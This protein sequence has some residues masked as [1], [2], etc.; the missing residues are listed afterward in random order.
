MGAYIYFAVTCRQDKLF[1]L[2][3]YLQLEGLYP[4]HCSQRSQSEPQYGIMGSG[5]VNTDAVYENVMEKFR[6][7]N[8]DK[9][10]MFV[11]RSYAPVYKAIS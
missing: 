9:Y 2:D 3:D 7:G 6:W 1:Y 8:F 10:K 5:R 4:A 11:D